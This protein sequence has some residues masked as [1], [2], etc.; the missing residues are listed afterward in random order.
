MLMAALVLVLGIQTQPTAQSVGPNN[1]GQ[2]Q[3][4]VSN[5]HGNQAKSKYVPGRFIVKF[6]SEGPEA[7]NE[8]V[9]YLLERNGKFKDAVSDRSDSLDEL[10]KKHNVKKA[11]SQFIERYGLT[12]AD[13]RQKQEQLHKI[14]KIKHQSRSQRAP[15]DA[16]LPDL[17]NVYVLDVSPESDIEAIV[18]EF[19]ADPHVEYAQPDYVVEA[20]MVPN[21]PYYAIAVQIS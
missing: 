21:D 6:K 19:Q 2:G 20:N 3:P 11:K 18:Q 17:S 5:N 13:A 16:M 4:N 14:S 9:E 7:V 8:D 1:P 10:I 15:K 12:T